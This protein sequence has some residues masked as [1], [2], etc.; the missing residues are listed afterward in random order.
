MSWSPRQESNLYLPLRRRPF[1][2]LNY[3]ED[4][5]IVPVFPGTYLVSVR[6][7]SSRPLSDSGYM[8]WPMSCW[9]MATYNAFP[10][11]G[12]EALVKFMRDFE[13]D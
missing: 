7:A 3:G 2:P 8:R 6:M 10:M 1:Y 4:G 12:V 11:E 9:T 5:R 13:T